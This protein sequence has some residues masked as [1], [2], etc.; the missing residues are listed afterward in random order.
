M[1]TYDL[2]SPHD[3]VIGKLL[4]KQASVQPEAEWLV[5]ESR[6]V[7]FA[8]ADELVNRYANG[9][10]ALGAGPGKVVA[11][12][13]EPSIEVVLLSF[14]TARIGGIF[15]T[16]STDFSGRFLANAIAAC[17]A[18]VLIVDQAIA[19]RLDK[20]ETVPGAEH[21]LVNGLAPAG[22]HPVQDLAKLLTSAAEP[23]AHI[24]TWLDP[25]QVWWS[26]GTTGAPKGV[27]H[28]HSSVLMQVLS[29]DRD[30]RAGDTLYSCTPVY[31][32]SSWT[33]TIYPSLVYGVRAA[34]DAKFSVSRFWD[35]INLFRATHAFTLGA[36]HMHLWNAEPKPSDLDNTLRRFAAMPMAPEIIR[37]FKARFG[38]E[39][40]R[41]GYGT[42]E[43]FRV[44]D[45]TDHAGD[46]RSGAVLGYP[47]PHLEVAL[48]DEED[49]P[50]TDGEAG[51]ICIRPKAPGMIFS[52]YFR[53]AARTAE[54]WRSLWHHTGDMAMRGADGLYRF[55]DRKKDYIRYKG[56]NMSMF[57]VEDVV[58]RHPAVKDVAAFGIE[59]AELES[60]S[61]LMISV[62]VKD[63]ETLDAPALARYINAEAPYYFVPRFIDF[64]ERLPRNDHGRLVKQDLRDLGVTATAWDREATDFVIERD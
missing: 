50:V 52:G 20:L 3:R 2:S 34:I 43:T 30:I 62:V 22:V 46:D 19:G 37:Q 54:T 8:Q 25:V 41:Q 44:F 27:M 39:D 18:H 33:G 42:S 59:S 26:S 16:V 1:Y 28:S 31:L 57:E 55:A 49:M 17:D 11:M 38:I 60:E 35:R 5:D 51:E 32:G 53:D 4:A 9:L 10:S 40:M 6:T 47:V 64:V 21:I 29:H 56:R 63:G 24:A 36:M 58:M 15:M 23:P 61:E 12:I 48:L 7:T 13:M 14:A 45:E